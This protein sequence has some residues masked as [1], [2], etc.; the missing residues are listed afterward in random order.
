MDIDVEDLGP[1]DDH[2]Q[3]DLPNLA[4][5][6]AFLVSGRP[7]ENLRKNFEQF[8]RPP[9]KTKNVSA[10]VTRS[11]ED[12]TFSLRLTKVCSK[13]VCSWSRYWEPPLE[14]G[15]FR[16]R[17][18]CRCGAILWDDFKELRPG[19]A[20][21]LRKSLEADEKAYVERPQRPA[22][23]AQ[24]STIPQTP[25]TAYLPG[26]NAGFATANSTSEPS[27]V[28]GSGSSTNPA[29]RPID[30]P[31]TGLPSENFR[32]IR[33]SYSSVSA[34]GTIRSDSPS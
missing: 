33:S 13:L 32:A 9:S 34:K 21:D 11:Q 18:T 25:P 20:E 4:Y 1:E 2:D 8:V 12:T 19:A 27:S 26:G 15:K 24:Q 17:W 7:F 22:N 10:P 5:V 3:L 23:E 28:S 6:N 29:N 31:S 16:V 14:G 30:A